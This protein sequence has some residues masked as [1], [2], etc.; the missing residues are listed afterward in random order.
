MTERIENFMPP[1]QQRRPFRQ[2]LSPIGCWRSALL[3]V[4]TVR[5]GSG[6]SCLHVSTFVLPAPSAIVVL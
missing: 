5:L 4:V 1:R 2:G 6:D 3:V